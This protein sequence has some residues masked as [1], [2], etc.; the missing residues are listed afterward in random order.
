[1]RA[2]RKKMRGF[3]L[4]ELMIVVA[5]IGVLAAL[6]IFGVRRYIL[7]AKT[8]EARNSLGGIAKAAEQAFDRELMPGAILTVG[9][10]IGGASR[11][12]GSASATVPSAAASIQGKKYQSSPSEWTTGT[13][14]DGWACVRFQVQDPQYYMYT[15]ANTG[16]TGAVGDS[17]TAMANGDLDGNSVLST[18]RL[19]GLIQ[20]GSTGAVMVTVAPA[21]FETLADE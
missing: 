4:V 18:F 20:S 6:A 5:I 19:D 1:M 15:Y 8:A 11:L 16:T 3:T 17:F 9:N 10:S 21:I 12:C 7:N 14:T 2:I 13:T